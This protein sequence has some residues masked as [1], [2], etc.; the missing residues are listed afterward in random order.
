MLWKTGKQK[1]TLCKSALAIDPRVILALDLDDITAVRE[2]L[3]RIGCN[4]STVKVGMKLFT[5]YGPELVTELK[6]RGYNVFLDLKYHDIPNTVKTACAE[7]TQLGVSMLTIHCLGGR[8]MCR[9]AV[10][11]AVTASQKYG[12]HIPVILGVT[13]LTSLGQDAVEEIGITKPIKEEAVSL[14]SMAISEGVHGIVCSAHEVADIKGHIKNDFIAVT[15]GIRLPEAGRDDQARVASPSK[16]VKSG[17]DYIV[18]GRPVYAAD[19]PVSALE[20]IYVDL[21]G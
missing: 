17:A 13:V 21:R 6:N 7:A 10:E 16:A 2:L 11:G 15:P 4:V 3:D 5:K 12:V 9:A 8:E 19:D 1:N 14:A 20:K 18:V